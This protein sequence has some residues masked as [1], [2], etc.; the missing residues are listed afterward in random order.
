MPHPVE[1][2]VKNKNDM[3]PTGFGEASSKEASSRISCVI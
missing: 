2:V 1:E 3:G